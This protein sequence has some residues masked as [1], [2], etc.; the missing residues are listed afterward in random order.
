M[1]PSRHAAQGWARLRIEVRGAVQGVGFRPFV[2]RTACELALTGWVRNDAR[3]VELEVEGVPGQIE[4]FRRRLVEDLPARAAIHDCVETWVAPQ[5]MAGFAIRASEDA[6]AP[7]AIVLADGAPC[8]D[9]LREIGDPADRRH[10]YPFTNCTHCGPRFTIV[11]GLPYD[12][13]RTTMRDFV[14]CPACRAEYEDPRD[15]RFHAQPNACPACGPRL[16]LFDAS[17]ATEAVGDAALRQAGA[18]VRA[19]RI[20]AFKGLG[21][22]LLLCTAADEDAVQRL[23]RRKHRAAK[24]LAVLVADVA[25]ARALCRVST[26]A[27][28]RL[29]SPEAPILL[30]PRRTDAPL[31]P[32]VAPGFD[33]V[34]VMLPSS[35]LHHLLLAEVGAPV[36]ATS[37]NRSDEPICIEDEEAR[38]RL[39]GIADVFLGHDRDIARHVDDGVEFMLG[40]VP[41]PVRRARGRAPLPVRLRAPV[42]TLLALGGHLKSAIALAVG[43]Q[44]FLSQHIGDLDT[45]EA[46]A[47][48]EAVIADFLAMYRA[49]PVALVHDLHPDYASTR[50][51]E[52]LARRTDAPWADLAGRPR[53]A[54]QHH[55]AHL[56]ACLAEHGRTGPALGVTWDGTGYAADGTVWGGEFLRGDAHEVTRVARLRPFRL[57]GAEGAVHEP[58]R[59][60]AALLWEFQGPEAFEALPAGT[61]ETGER[62]VLARM[63]ETGFRAPIT[64]SMGRLFDGVAA[65]LGL[66]ARV[67]YEG[68][69]AIA[70]ETAARGSR[71]TGAYDLPIRTREGGILEL[72]WGPL[73]TVLLRDR[74]RGVAT[75]IMAA[76]FHHALVE[77]LVAVAQRIAEP[78]V[79][80]TGG[81]FLN[82]LLLEGAL[83]RLRA[84]GFDALHHRE[85]PTGDGGL[86]LGQVAVAAARLE[87]S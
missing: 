57:P 66:G 41:C 10:R 12:R 36:V 86:A 3:G 77:A 9:C 58:R 16:R 26:A 24:P 62:R 49:T 7:T 40:D 64:T 43:D 80:L 11:T 70:L 81:C 27:A 32:S 37:G 78:V 83:A 13:R 33:T 25:A 35:P 4:C 31:A 59:V 52:H 55:H 23:R 30:L 22:F 84:E 34:G 5:R 76:R 74:R 45:V 14:M 46:C 50:W 15:R 72:D 54:V 1:V 47:A 38:T 29:A 44:V 82:R 28:L 71:E 68:Q 65:L 42:P 19:G 67:A 53:I 20:V 85:V 63:L 39:A 79:A 56:A 51:A 6:E 48:F 8:A 87:R 60:A 69:A 18:A 17:G 61:F 21:G 75:G 2:H 73:L